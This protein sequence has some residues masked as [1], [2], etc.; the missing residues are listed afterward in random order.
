MIKALYYHLVDGEEV[1]DSCHRAGVTQ[2][3]FSHRMRRLQ[4]LNLIIWK[5]YPFYVS[6][7]DSRDSKN[8]GQTGA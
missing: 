1:S 7:N 8:C 3:S 6:M 4:D 2:G 5:M